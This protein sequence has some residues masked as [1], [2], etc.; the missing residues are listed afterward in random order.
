MKSDPGMVEARTHLSAYVE[1]VRD[2][3]RVVTIRTYRAPV[4]CLVPCDVEG[5]P[6]LDAIAAH[7]R[8]IES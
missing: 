1:L 8:G 4:A 7:R 5:H 3:R 6:D 2:E